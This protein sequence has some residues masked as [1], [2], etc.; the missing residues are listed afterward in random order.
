MEVWPSK[1]HGRLSAVRNAEA[2]IEYERDAAGRIK[3]ARTIRYANGTGTSATPATRELL[4]VHTQ[5]YGWNIHDEVESWSFPRAG[6]QPAALASTSPWMGRIDIARDG[7]G[8]VTELKDEHGQVHYRASATAPG[9]LAWRARVAGANEIRSE[10]GFDD[11]TDVPD[12]VTLPT[13]AA[14]NGSGMPLWSQ[15]SVAGVTRTGSATARDGA[16]RLSAVNDLALVGRS[17]AWTYDA[18]SRLA[19][20]SLLSTDPSAQPRVTETLLAA[21][22]R[23]ARTFTPFF[24]AAQREVLG[25]EVAATVPPSWTATQRPAHAIESLALTFDGTS[26]V[27]R[28]HEFTGGNRTSDGVW[29][30]SYDAFDRLRAMTRSSAGTTADAVARRVEYEYDPNDRLVGRRALA[31]DGTGGWKVEERAAVL[32][33]DGLQARTTM[34]WDPVT[35]R[36]V[37]VATVGS[38]HAAAPAD[39]GMLRQYLHGDQSY[40]DPIQVRIAT[41]AGVNPRVLFPVIDDAT[42]SVTAVLNEKGDFAERVLYADAYGDA[43]RYLHGALVDRL[44]MQAKKNGSGTIETVQIRAHLSEPIVHN[45][46]AG[47][48]LLTSRNAAGDVVAN[49]PAATLEDEHTM[50]W[51]LSGA[52][53]S[54]LTTSTSVTSLDV[55]VTSTLRAGGWGSAPVQAPPEWARRIHA[56][57]SSTSASPFV[58]SQPLAAARA[59]IASVATGGTQEQTLYEIDDLYLAALD[60]SRS[61]AAV[62][63]HGYSFTEPAHGRIYAR[64]R[65]YHPQTGTF[66]SPDPL[67]YRDSANLYA[68]A[69]GDPVNRRDPLGMAIDGGDV[70]EDFRRA[71]RAKQEARFR[72]RAIAED[73]TDRRVD[74]ELQRFGNALMKRLRGL[75]IKV[76]ATDPVAVLAGRVTA[77]TADGR[78]IKNPYSGAIESETTTFVLTVTGV[79]VASPAIALAAQKSKGLAAA[80]VLDEILGQAIGLNPSLPLNVVHGSAKYIIKESSPWALAPIQRGI[81]I[82][83]RL[84]VTDYA[85]WYRIGK[86]NRGFFELIDFQKGRDLVS[87]KTVDASSSTAMSRMEAEIDRLAEHAG[88]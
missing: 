16:M 67:G 65:W 53:W 20:A 8:N 9:R 64:A 58:Y 2:S 49:A 62:G 38:S 80:L 82:E 7:A 21:D 26:P 10:F 37:A 70:R 71:D 28:G 52:E 63:F 86:E 30:Y 46:L 76:R 68:F 13:A 88:S 23:Q 57:V 24:T 50:L 81:F 47:G 32:T 39:S 72:A 5:T 11:G 34:I 43:P 17:S 35:D 31:P 75:G 41:A 3:V 56:G 59:F 61:K 25:S 40:D 55:S 87:L 15:T 54:A 22:F 51:D 74:D 44:T 1:P 27:T 83:E 77:V 60:D 78:V 14:T 18:K 85:D 12:A 79:K 33:R 6:A 48:A 69:G 29:S 4:D 84:A 45:T 42:A 73:A 36:L 66:L 19:T